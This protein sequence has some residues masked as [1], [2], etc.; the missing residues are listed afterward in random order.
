MIYTIEIAMNRFQPL[1]DQCNGILLYCQ[2]EIQ[3]ATLACRLLMP[4]L[5]MQGLLMPELI[6]QGCFLIAYLRMV[7]ALRY[8][9]RSSV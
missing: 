6:M 4:E 7:A 9:Y 5:I 1:A 8:S 2:L 3:P